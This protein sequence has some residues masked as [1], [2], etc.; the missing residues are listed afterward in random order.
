[1]WCGVV[2]FGSGVDRGWKAE[3]H[4]HGIDFVPR[5]IAVSVFPS[6]DQ[7]NARNLR[8][9]NG[10]Y[11]PA[12]RLPQDHHTEIPS[13]NMIQEC[14]TKGVPLE[15]LDVT[16]YGCQVL[17]LLL[18]GGGEEGSAGTD[19]MLYLAGSILL[20]LARFVFVA[21]SCRSILQAKPRSQGMPCT[22]CKLLYV[23]NYLNP[24]LGSFSQV[25]CSMT[26]FFTPLVH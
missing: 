3:T 20:L 26:G 15:P 14:R 23:S 18:Y 11:C 7:Q 9:C 21:T 19:G 12:K 5:L 22:Q 16:T 24:S 17:R 4:I 1:M 10:T 6:C 2:R 8:C 13:A 25:C